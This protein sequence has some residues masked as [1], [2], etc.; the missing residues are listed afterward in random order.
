MD[1]PDF[2]NKCYQTSDDKRHNTIWSVNNLVNETP[3]E[4]E[5]RLKNLRENRGVWV[6]D[7]E[8]GEVIRKEE[9]EARRALRKKEIDA[10]SISFWKDEFAVV[11][12]GKRMSKRQL[13]EYCKVHNKVWENG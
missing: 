10:P 4:R 1:K 13:K 7:E 6:R 3:E 11:A 12:T 8:T 2:S 9:Y 5:E